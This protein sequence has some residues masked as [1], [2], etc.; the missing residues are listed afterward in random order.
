MKKNLFYII[1]AVIAVVAV[2]AMLVFVFSGEQAEAQ[3]IDVD[4]DGT[5]KVVSYVQYGT[6]TQIDDEFVVIENGIISNYRS[7]EAEPYATSAYTLS[8]SEVYG[9]LDVTLTDLDTVLV[10]YMPTDNYIC[11]YDEQDVYKALVRHGNADMSP[12]EFDPAILD[13]MWDVV[14][15]HVNEEFTDEKLE[16][17]DGTLAAY[18]NGAE[19][20]V[21]TVPYVWT[22]EGYLEIEA[23]GKTMRCLKRDE[24]N[25][26]FVELPTGYVWELSKVG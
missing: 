22:E 13:G 20:P 18:R 4:L 8:L 6:G 15:R 14:F 16:F 9:N 25:I 5:W 12:V 1:G 21:A 3:P 7:G 17:T 23:L 10:M 2:A 19:E 24:N 11:L 26:Y